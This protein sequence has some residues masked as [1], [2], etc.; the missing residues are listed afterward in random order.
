MLREGGQLSSTE[1]MSSQCGLKMFY[2]GSSWRIRH[3]D[4]NS[5]VCFS[6]QMSYRTDF[7]FFKSPFLSEYSEKKI[8]SSR[9]QKDYWLLMIM[10]FFKKTGKKTENNRKKCDLNIYIWNTRTSECLLSLKFCLCNITLK[11]WNILES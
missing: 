1:Y 5:T 11:I 9:F 7:A 2:S 8:H 6:P 10:N 4:K 3:S